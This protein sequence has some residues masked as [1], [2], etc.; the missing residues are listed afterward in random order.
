MSFHFR[1]LFPRTASISFYAFRAKN[2]H[3]LQKV[4]DFRI[5]EFIPPPPQDFTLIYMFVLRIA[6][7]LLCCTKGHLVIVLIRLQSE[8]PSFESQPRLTDCS[9]S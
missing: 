5:H 6:Y 4:E 7:F 2:A 8:G 3:K 1:L 9:F